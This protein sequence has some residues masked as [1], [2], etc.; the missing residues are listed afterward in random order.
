MEALLLITEKLPLLTSS[1]VQAIASKQTGEKSPEDIK[2]E[3]VEAFKKN[4]I[5]KLFYYVLAGYLCL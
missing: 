2:A 5:N 3:E 4:T 1:K